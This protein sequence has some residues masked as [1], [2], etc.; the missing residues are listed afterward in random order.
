MTARLASRPALLLALPADAVLLTID[1]QQGFDL[2]ARY[3]D[4]SQIYS[5][6]D[7]VVVYDRLID[8]ALLA[9]AIRNAQQSLVSLQKLGEQTA[10]LHRQYL[11][12]QGSVRTFMRVLHF[13]QSGDI[14]DFPVTLTLQYAGRKSVRLV[15]PI[16]EQT[17]DMR[18]PLAG[19]LQGMNVSDD[20]GSLA[21][22]QRGS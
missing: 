20:D 12:G 10:Q 1:M 8:P 9:E 4:V 16:T 14:F 11:D 18:V 17:V 7:D 22:V 13:E 21:E 2:F 15:V 3:R 19:P 5:E 6:I